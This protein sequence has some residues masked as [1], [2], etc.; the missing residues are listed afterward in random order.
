MEPPDPDGPLPLGPPDPTDINQKVNQLLQYA[1][2]TFPRCWWGMCGPPKHLDIVKGKAEVKDQPLKS[3]GVRKGLIF[4]EKKCYNEYFRIGT[5]PPAWF[6]P[7][8]IYPYQIQC[9]RGR[10]KSGFGSEM[11]A[12]RTSH[13][14]V[15]PF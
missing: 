4:S 6:V 8:T 15:L 3:C 1:K 10:L 11:P 14:N 7:W 5:G 13:Y 2:N 9:Y 12:I